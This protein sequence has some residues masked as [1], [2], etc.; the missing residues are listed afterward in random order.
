MRKFK[1]ADLFCGCGGFSQGFASTTNFEGV[2]AADSWAAA[3]DVY[4]QNIPSVE[5]V[6]MD[7]AAAECQAHVAERLR[8]NV[9]VLLGGP[10]CQGFS[11]LGVRR[12]GDKRSSLVDIF[13]ELARQVRPKV[14]FMENV[15]GI[16]SMRHRSG[17]LY[18]A[19]I[20]RM[21]NPTTKTEWHCAE[22]F[23]DMLNFGIPQ[24]RTR[25]LFI[26]VRA[27]LAGAE[28][29]LRLITEGL[30]SER[31][32]RSTLRQAIGDLPPI[33]AGEGSD[34]IIVNGGRAVYNHKAMAHKK[35]LLNR[36]KY[37]PPGGGLPDVPRRLLTP[38]LRKMVDGGY[39][40]GGHVKNI[41]GRMVW[42]QP[43]GTVVAGIDKI[44]CGRFIHPEA[45]R[46]LTPR[47]CA[48]IQSFPDSFRFKGSAVSQYYM[49]GN[50]VPPRFS[51]ALGQITASALDSLENEA[52]SRRRKAA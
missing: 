22:V 21:L 19:A 4:S 25:Y 2:L 10:P 32:Q 48:R 6:V 29:V 13:M 40:S 47:E 49:I 43:S 16:V 52:S 33:S 7:L 18:P 37:V 11:T 50:A 1:F 15:R 34:E 46:L 28:D 12:P 35:P 30:Q 17:E 39:G 42:D 27:D 3:I 31:R 51:S 26:A 14:L 5:A 20:Y 24:T 45:D 44:T 23:V 38:H 36:L 41:Y 9:D 8:G